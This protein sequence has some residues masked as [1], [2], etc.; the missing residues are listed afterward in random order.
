MPAL[1][2]E[3]MPSIAQQRANAAQLPGAINPNPTQFKGASE[4]ETRYLQD[5]YALEVRNHK[6]GVEPAT[7]LNMNPFPIVVHSPLFDGLIVPACPLDKPYTMLVIRSV[8]YQPKDTE[9]QLTPVDFQPY[10]LASEFETQTQEYGGVVVF[11]GDGANI[12]DLLKD[13]LVSGLWAEAKKKHIDY[14]KRKKQ[15]ADSEWNTPSRSGARNI[16]D[17]NRNLTRILIREKLLVATPE[18]MDVTRDEAQIA[19]AC[20]H[21]LAEPKKGAHVCPNCGSILDAKKAWKERYI[22]DPLNESLR[23]LSRADL[24]ELNISH[25]IEETYSEMDAR[26]SREAA[27]FKKTG[28]R[29]VAK[30]AQAQE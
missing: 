9:G 17:I 20:P 26:M 19:D 30:P 18:W 1:T 7:I 10:M 25:Y 28:K 13:K 29:P 15:E 8:R 16:T 6:M 3:M 22:T 4:M 21:C 5:L 11:R 12:A 27:E 24:E 23:K 14:A 2:E